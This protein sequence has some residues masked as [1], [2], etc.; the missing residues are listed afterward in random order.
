MS[1]ST[2]RKEK[3]K[4][5][6]IE[7]ELEEEEDFII[8][9]LIEE[10]MRSDQHKDNIDKKMMN[11]TERKRKIS[12]Q[13]LETGLPDE[14]KGCYE[15]INERLM[16]IEKHLQSLQSISTIEEKNLQDTLLKI[17]KIEE[18]IVVQE[19]KITNY[20]ALYKNWQRKL[21]NLEPHTIHLEDGGTIERN[22]IHPYYLDPLVRIE[23][24]Y[25]KHH[26]L[27]ST[28]K[29]AA[30]YIVVELVY[31]DMVDNLQKDM[32][33]H[34]PNVNFKTSVISFKTKLYKVGFSICFEDELQQQPPH[35]HRLLLL[36]DDLYSWL[37][38]NDTVK[39]CNPDGVA[40]IGK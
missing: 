9:M 22:I 16:R 29:M 36:F 23:K 6:E 13:L 4:R 30:E 31:N 40:L 32:K 17:N 34:F 15:N 37:Q 1:L 27:T 26:S 19:N 12:A 14:V 10:C 24:K 33:K 38:A 39:S 2:L 28:T 7:E 3:R 21:Q 20:M 25:N 35:H 5:F 18:R 8:R 11:I